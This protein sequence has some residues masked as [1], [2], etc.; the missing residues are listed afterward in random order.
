VKRLP[1]IGVMGSGSRRYEDRASRVG[2]WIAGAGYHLLTGGGAGVMDAVTE[3]FV[4]VSPRAGLALGILPADV[5]S[6]GACP[7]SGYPNP[8]V[9]LVIQTHLS[10]RGTQG[11]GKF[12]RNH[13][14]VLS[15]DV[16]IIFPGSSGTASEARLAVFYGRPC[17]AY[18][19]SD[20]QLPTL[21]ASIPVE[22]SFDAV[23]EFVQ[24]VLKSQTR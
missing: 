12:S 8:W 11:D 24:N 1:V 22:S 16:T 2:A 19:T 14:N 20:D 15:S 3:A 9:E 17:V 10:E 5:E 7:P 21:P 13:L 23:I 18:L 6:S 4:S